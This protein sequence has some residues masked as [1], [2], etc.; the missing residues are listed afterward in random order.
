MGDEAE[1][2]GASAVRGPCEE[3]RACVQADQS[4]RI[5]DQVRAYGRS[6]VASTYVAPR[7]CMALNEREDN[8]ETWR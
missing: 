8:R 5:W 4:L 1:A 7:G 6:W 2:S 3:G